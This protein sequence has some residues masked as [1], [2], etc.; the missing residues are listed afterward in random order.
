M[1]RTEKRVM[2]AQQALKTLL[3][4]GASAFTLLGASVASAQETPAPSAAPVADQQADSQASEIIVTGSRIKSPVATS[5]SPLQAVTAQ[6]IARTGKTNVQEILQTN[7]TFGAP[8]QSRTSS[9]YNALYAGLST[10]NLRNLGANRTLVLID[11]RR[12]VAGVPGTAQVDLSMIPSPFVERIDV[13]T[14]GASAVY[15]SDAVAGVVNFIY[16]KKFEGL[17][18]NGQSGISEKGDDSQYS[19][20]LTIGH[21][22][23]D[24][25]GNV[26]VYAGYSKEGGV[27]SVDRA[28]SSTDQTS[29]GAQQRSNS[30][31][32]ANLIAAQNLFKAKPNL[33]SVVPA[34][35]FNA[36][37]GNFIIDA[38][39]TVRPFVGA[40]DGFD[41]TPYDAIAVPIERRL[42]AARANYEVGSNINVFVEGNYGNTKS[43]SALEPSPLVPTGSLGIFRQGNGRYNIE[44]VFTNPNN[45][46]QS[47]LVINP[48]VPAGLYNV[49]TDTNGDGFRDIAVSRRLLD[50]GPRIGT[51]DRTQLRAVIG[52]EG[53]IGSNW[54]WEATYNWGQ[55]RASSTFSGLINQDRVIQALNVVP[56][57]YD[58]NGNGN[59]TEAI[60]AS[61]EARAEGCVP[62]NVYGAGKASPAA[63]SYLAATST[64]DAVQTLEIAGA[65][66][67]GTLYHLPAGDVQVA[68]GVE[69]RKESS[70]E[71]FDPLSQVA[72]NSYIQ[73]TNTSGSFD[74]KEAYGEIVV[75][76]LHDTPG[77]QQLTLRGAGRVSDYSTVGTFA[78]YNGGI[79]WSP[80]RDIRL[81]AVYAKAVRAPNIGELFAAPSATVSSV[82]DPCSGITATTTG[83]TATIC[84]AN[85]GVVANMAANGGVFTLSQSDVQGV[86]GLNLSNPN[87]KQETAR[88]YTLGAVIN[89][90]SIHALRNLTVTVDYYNIKLDN[91]IATTS[92][93]FILQQCYQNNDP[94]FCALISRRT[95]GSGPYSAG[96]IQQVNSQLINSGGAFTEGIDT[97]FTYRQ[98]LADW[99]IADGSASLSVAY[100]HLIKQYSIP[101]DGAAADRSDGEINN[102]K[103]RFQ[104]SLTGDVGNF[105]FTMNGQYIGASYLDDQYRKLFVLADGSLPD[106]NLFRIGAKFYTDLQVRWKVATK[107]EFYVGVNNLFD[108][109]PPPVITGLTGSVTGTE[110]AAATYDP[111]GRRF[112][113]GFRLKL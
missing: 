17:E 85:P 24:G 84:R 3:L 87:I 16:K 73:Q 4:T 65:N 44:Q 80:V 36:G 63:L 12:V 113:S 19:A 50:F 89:P 37:T 43:T 99:G 45:P 72:R 75:P 111:I 6:D 94:N 60:C 104:V 48:L 96:S 74:V 78:A 56:D 33:S 9:N 71:T 98:N 90:A 26:M 11:G 53:K 108:T 66:L 41:R 106:K 82:N 102:P 76:I 32:D 46:A 91:A 97:T 29:I 59:T 49:A 69:Y 42:F 14:G 52:V 100:T 101:L 13:L 10:V 112:Y 107:F 25:R 57:I 95:V 15:G 39:G 34:S 64:H 20:N 51:F 77:I 54:S 28:R 35:T 67:S 62:Y 31:T 18:L 79:E 109:Q 47:Q 68:I 58:V 2:P 88:T 21:N 92:R 93:D 61:A 110:T 83:T 38:N 30:A 8:G 86:G 81:R 105:G 5:P 103:D 27:R 55:T 70:R 1:N 23:D 7:P 40:T 22:F